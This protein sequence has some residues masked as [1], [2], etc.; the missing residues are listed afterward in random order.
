MV[1][2]QLCVGVS[3]QVSGGEATAR[4]DREVNC[5]VGHTRRE[6]RGGELEGEE[7]VQI[8]EEEECS[9]EGRE[10]R[11]KGRRKTTPS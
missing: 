11:G 2:L 5:Q 7:L 8:P 10:G 3:Q 6:A 4:R 1:Q 9:E